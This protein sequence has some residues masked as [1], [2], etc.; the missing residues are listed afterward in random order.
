MAV[1]HQQSVHPRSGPCRAPD[2]LNREVAETA[3]GLGEASPTLAA[4]WSGGLESQ[5]GV[6]VLGL[7]EVKV[8]GSARTIIGLWLWRQ[9]ASLAG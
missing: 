6:E 7:K 1:G 5:Q 8:S 9:A 3:A 4:F 2:D